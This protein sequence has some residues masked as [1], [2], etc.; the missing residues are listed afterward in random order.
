M[1][2]TQAQAAAK[3]N[4]KSIPAGPDAKANTAATAALPSSVSS[5]STLSATAAATPAKAKSTG[6]ATRAATSNASAT[7][8]AGAVKKPSFT[9]SLPP[10]SIKGGAPSLHEKAMILAAER[11]TSADG[12]NESDGTSS[13]T[14]SGGS[15]DLS[16][17][18]DGV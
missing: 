8:G 5:S 11:S 16:D 14:A 1:T 15:R 9:L 13:P 17:Y 6:D 3:V 12:G 18:T 4:A 10:D 2:G 7:G